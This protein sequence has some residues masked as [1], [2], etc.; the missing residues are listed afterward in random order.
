MNTTR[1]QAPA[2]LP[3]QKPDAIPFD[4]DITR[5]SSN[6]SS[7]LHSR[8]SLQ[9]IPSQNSETEAANI[10]PEPANVVEAD[11]E[12]GG[13]GPEDE[14]T[15]NNSDNNNN[16]SAPA[17]PPAFPPGL[18]PA[19]FPEGGFE[20]WLVV[21]G[22]W[23]GLFCTFGLVNCI[24]VFERY[25][26]V[27]GPLSSYSQGTVSWILSVE[28]F[29]MTLG[30]VIFGRIYDSYGPRWLL[31][32]GTIVYVFGLMMTSLSTQ[33]YQFFLAQGVCS[34]LGSSAVFNACMSSVVSWFSRRRAAAFGI[35]VS[36]SSL[37]G[38][39][40]PIM[41]DKLITRVGFPWA[42]RAMAFMML[43]LL[44]IACLTVHSRLP[45]RPRA[46]QQQQQ[47]HFSLREYLPA[48]REPAFSLIAAACFLF[49]W[50]MLLPFNY[51]E[52]QAQAAGM[53]PTLVPYL[54]PIVNAV[55]IAGRI[56]PGIV[57]DRIGRYN[58]MLCI[59][60]FSAVIS[61]ALW[62]PGKSTG[63]ILAYSVLFGFSSGGFV[64]LYPTL[65]AQISDIRQIGIRTGTAFGVVGFAALTGSPI[66]G[67]IADD[68]NGSFTGLQLFCGFT[69]VASVFVFAAARFVL[70]GGSLIKKV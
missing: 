27:G 35:M 49:F 65:I 47:Q 60:A 45:P 70:V 52:L 30:N 57:A 17:A 63:A 29:F 34:S 64:S 14:D 58:V 5:H 40:L 22:G 61:L 66:A 16:N 62:I 39:I 1:A 26:Y 2:A 55:S 44:I 42:M 46:Q 10:Y 69:M 54:L 13:L 15:D 18:N 20:A 11:L 53:S 51:I 8:R 50:G 37:G 12:K 21:F 23:C 68:Q 48:F 3:S 41:L 6:A 43:G 7:H 32:L 19:D 28:V 38:V 24:G 4:D 67:S 33:Y 31:I 25:Y 9:R 59:T 36:D 56:L